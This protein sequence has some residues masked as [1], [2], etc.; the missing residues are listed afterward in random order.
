VAEASDL[1][2]DRVVETLDRLLSR[3]GLTR[4]GVPVPVTESVLNENFRVETSAGPRF[5]RF[6]HARVASQ[7][8]DLEH[9]VISWVGQ[10]GIPIIAPLTATD[11]T[12]KQAIEDRWFSI[13]PWVEFRQLHASAPDTAEAMALGEMLGRL[14]K[15][16]A[17]FTEVAVPEGF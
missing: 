5:V 14:H 16:L 2:P 12:T 13:F 6:H 7:S 11:G 9:R 15:T 8:I 10:R 4:R 17:G 1:V 3:Y